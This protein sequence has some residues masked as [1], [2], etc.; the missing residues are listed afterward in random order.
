MAVALSLAPPLDPAEW[1]G[2]TAPAPDEIEV[3]TWKDDGSPATVAVCH[4]AAERDLPDMTPAEADQLAV[5][6]AHA[7]RQARSA[8]APAA[9]PGC[10]PW[11]AGCDGSVHMSVSVSV[12]GTSGSFCQHIADRARMVSPPPGGTACDVPVSA[13]LVRVE[14]EETNVEVFHG[15]EIVKVPLAF[16]TA[17]AD[18]ITELA[19]IGQQAVTT[20]SGPAPQMPPG[21]SAPPPFPP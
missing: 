5:H 3:S 16:A 13:Q 14:G 4:V 19:R 12:P 10:P 18:S 8:R 15:D 21:G 11:C 7:A 17:L 9:M 2:L 1:V 20:G 6:L